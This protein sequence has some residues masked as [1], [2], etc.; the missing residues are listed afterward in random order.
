VSAD[1]RVIVSGL[2]RAIPGQ[3]VEPAAAAAAAAPARKG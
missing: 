3:K 1:D 2:L